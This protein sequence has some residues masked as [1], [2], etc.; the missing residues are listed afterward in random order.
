MGLGHG[1]HGVGDQLAR[2]QGIAHAEVTHGDAVVHADG[3]EFERQ[4]TGVAHRV[5]GD[6][7]QFLQVYV[8]GNQ[9][10]KRIADTE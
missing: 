1:L 9:L 7:T 10:H 8:T 3:V 6:G 4:A 2:G 5:T